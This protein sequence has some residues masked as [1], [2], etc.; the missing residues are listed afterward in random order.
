M[1]GWKPSPA[2]SRRQAPAIQALVFAAAS[3]IAEGDYRRAAGSFDAQ[4]DANRLYSS[5]AL[6]FA[7]P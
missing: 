1:D 2:S 5:S 7:Y 4:R 6:S 3:P